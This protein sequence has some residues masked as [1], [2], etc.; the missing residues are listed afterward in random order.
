MKR[1]RIRITLLVSATFIV[2]LSAVLVYINQLSRATESSVI[3]FMDELS[4]H[5]R[6]NIQMSWKTHGMNY[7]LFITE[8]RTI[9]TRRYR[10]CAAA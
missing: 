8:Q 9:N 7:P 6:Q 4:E 5:D 1:N 10:M 3:A 2:M